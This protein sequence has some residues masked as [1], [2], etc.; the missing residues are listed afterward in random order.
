MI[1]KDSAEYYLILANHWSYTGI[2][3][4][5]GLESCRA[6][7]EDSLNIADQWPHVKVCINPDARAY[8]A[9]RKYFPET[10]IR[11]K[12][13]LAGKKT[14]IIGGTYGQPMG[15]RSDAGRRSG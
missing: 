11:L 15:R 10:I 1:K 12:K 3:W 13:Y 2:G 5:L 6:S 14:E 8:A 9:L 4:Q 7:V